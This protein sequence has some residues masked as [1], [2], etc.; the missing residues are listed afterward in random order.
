MYRTG[1]FQ[2]MRRES[3]DRKQRSMQML[4]EDCMQTLSNLLMKAATKSVY[5]PATPNRITS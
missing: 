3:G 1:L 4:A 2:A 5:I